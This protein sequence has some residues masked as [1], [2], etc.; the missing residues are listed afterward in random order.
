MNRSIKSWC[1]T[2]FALIFS[3]TLMS[4]EL[5]DAR[6][7][8][9]DKGSSVKLLDTPESFLSEEAIK[10]RSLQN[11]ALTRADL[12]IAKEYL[13]MLREMGAVCIAKSKWLNYVY[14]RH[15]NPQLLATLPFVDQ[16]EFPRGH[17]SV[18]T[19]Q[20]SSDT[21]NYGYTNGQ[22]TML[23]GQYLHEQGYTGTG[24][25]IAVIDAGYHGFLQSSAFQNLR[26]TS[27]LKG[28][29]NFISND[30]NVY[31]GWGSHGTSV[32]SMMA[33]NISDTIIGTAPDANFWLLTTENIHQELP[34]EM[35]FWVMAAEYADSV[36][37]HII[38]SSLSYRVF[39]IPIHNL[40]Y[41]DMNGNTTV[42][43]RAADMAASKGILVIASAGNSGETPYPYISAPA[44]GDSV[45]TVGAVD[46]QEQYASFSSIG[47]TF[48]GRIKPDVVAQGAPVTMIDGQGNVNIEFGTSY[49]A[50]I[51]SGLAA[52]LIEA[53]PNR[54][55]EEIANFIRQS[56][57]HFTAPNDTIGYGLPDFQLAYAL[58]RPE[59]LIQEVQFDLY[60]NPIEDH[61]I[62]DA[63]GQKEWKA[64]LKIIDTHGRVVLQS[65]VEAYDTFRVNLNLN[66]GAYIVQLAGDIEGVFPIKSF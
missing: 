62:I 44:D 24:I 37:A 27:Q 18:L 8:L 9:K 2:A 39:D 41:S 46:W 42:I 32:L 50:P 12:P 5:T 30:S 54:H 3:T 22:I 48:D 63:K 15:S 34:E 56:A 51:I 19:A 40:S 7:F 60:P 55:S 4:Q 64:E 17:E 47:P 61:F 14:V 43:T 13:Q 58:H 28:S 52:C 21:L 38:N 53:Y 31:V 33:A 35:D 23:N 16:V 20:T 49:S 45:L 59:Y 36:G 29:H 6:L 25:N 65:H 26:N 57:D 1:A 66:P 11:I 10:R